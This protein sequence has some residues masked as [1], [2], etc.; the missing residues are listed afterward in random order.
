[1]ERGKDYQYEPNIFGDDFPLFLGKLRPRR[2]GKS[3]MPQGSSYTLARPLSPN[4]SS[5]EVSFNSINSE[6]IPGNRLK[7]VLHRERK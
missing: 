4:Q 7:G 6:F 2:S 5:F 3:A 1:M